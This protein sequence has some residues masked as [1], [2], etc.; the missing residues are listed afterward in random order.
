[1][2]YR[3]YTQ[4]ADLATDDWLPASEFVVGIDG[5]DP[6]VTDTDVA[7]TVPIAAGLVNDNGEQTLTGSSGG[8]NTTANTST[9]KEGAGTSDDTAQNLLVNDTSTAKVWTL[10]DVSSAGASIEPDRRIAFWLYVADADTLA[11]LASSGTALEARFGSDASNYYSLTRERDDL[12]VGWNW[13]TTNKANVDTLAE[14]GTVGSPVNYFQIRLTTNDA[15]DVWD[16][17]DVVYDL[18][19]QWVYADTTK[20]FV[21]DFP[22][23]ELSKRQATVRSFVSTVEANG[24]SLNRYGHTNTDATPKLLGSDSFPDES[25]SRFDEI[26]FIVRDRVE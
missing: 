22:T 7:T 20:D 26:A 13:V 18:L 11:K 4:N 15:A 12:A 25:K 14:T 5:L 8:T 6:I 9:F 24:F 21:E 16:A 1:M 23:L 2:V 10:T 3:A 17:G 19:R